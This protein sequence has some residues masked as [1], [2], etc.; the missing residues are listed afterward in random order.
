MLPIFL[1]VAVVAVAGLFGTWQVTNLPLVQPFLTLPG[2]EHFQFCL[3]LV[4][5]GEGSPSFVVNETNDVSSDPCPLLQNPDKIGVN[6]R[7]GS[8]DDLPASVN[9]GDNVLVIRHSD[10]SSWKNVGPA[11]DEEVA[12]D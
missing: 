6:P 2:Y 4:G 8:D 11:L 10:H 12:S 3:N 5:L 7:L 9:N 1:K